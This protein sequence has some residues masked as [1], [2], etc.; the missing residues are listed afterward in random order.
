MSY[1]F[2]NTSLVS[3]HMQHHHNE[4]III[5]KLSALLVFCDG[6][7]RSLVDSPVLLSL[8]RWSATTHHKGPVMLSLDIF[9]SCQH[10]QVVEQAVMLL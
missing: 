4:D 10:E 1:C 8:Y 6:N 7:H 2:W 5:N 9:F 3:Y